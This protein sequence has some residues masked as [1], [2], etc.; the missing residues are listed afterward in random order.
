LFPATVKERSL[1][2]HTDYLEHAVLWNEGNNQFKLD[3]LPLKSQVAPAYGIV[4]HDLDGD[5]NKDIWM[6]GNFY[7]LKP[8]VGR[9]DASRGVFLKGSGINRKFSYL[10]PKQAGIYVRGEVRD[11]WVVNGDKPKLLIAR[12]NDTMLKFERIE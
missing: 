6:G 4:A 10:A 5:G 2:Y 12:N 9:F 11:A 3:A 1:K 7:A 8:Q